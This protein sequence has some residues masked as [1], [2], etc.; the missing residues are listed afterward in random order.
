MYLLHDDGTGS[1]PIATELRLADT[2][3]Q[4]MRGLMFRPPLDAG[5]AMV[6]RF[7]AVRTRRIHAVFV[8]AA[9]D[10]VWVVDD[11]VTSVTTLRPWVGFGS[12]AA[13]LVVE[14]P[15]GAADPITE[16]DRVAL[17]PGTTPTG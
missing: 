15:P 4:R 6:F 9:F 11:R 5:E 3:L 8:R 14:L 1:E 13:D 2:P 12:A 17:A 16:D 10:V 7:G